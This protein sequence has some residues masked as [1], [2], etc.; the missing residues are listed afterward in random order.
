MKYIG[1]QRQNISLSSCLKIGKKYHCN[2]AFFW[3]RNMSQY[4]DFD[5]LAPWEQGG[6]AKQK[7]IKP[8]QRASKKRYFDDMEIG[9]YQKNHHH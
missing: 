3:D 2:R 1:T 9:A 5:E 8:R 4:K 7:K 6:K